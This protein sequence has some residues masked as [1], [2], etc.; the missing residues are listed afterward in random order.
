MRAKTL[1]IIVFGVAVGL[2][3]GRFLWSGGTAVETG[4]PSAAT[5]RTAATIWT[6]SMHPQ[7][8]LPSPGQCPI[9]GMDLIPAVA[10]SG[11]S[12]E[13]VLGEAAQKIAS[14]ETARVERRVLERE[15]RTVGRIELAEP[16]VSYLTARA[17]GRVERVFADF[18][19]T[20]VA[21]GDHLVDIYAPAL[22]IAQEELLIAARNAETGPGAQ[23]ETWGLRLKLARQKVLLLGLTEGQI[24]ALIKAKEP[25]FVLTVFAPVGGTVMSKNVQRQMYVKAGDPLYTIADLS[26]VWLFADIYEFELPWVALGQ[27]A[28]VEVEGVPGKAFAGTLDFIEPRVNEATRTIRVRLT[29]ENAERLLKPGMFAR[30]MILARIGPD[31]LRAAAPVRGRYYCRMH[32]EYTSDAP[33]RCAF[34][35]MELIGRPESQPASAPADRVVWTC[36]MHPEIR[37]DGPGECPICGM[38]LVEKKE[39]GVQDAERILAIPVDAVLDSGLRR[40]VYVERAPGKYEAVEVRLGPRAGEFYPVLEG[41]E[42]GLH[43]VARGGFL[44]DSQAQIEGRPSL[45]FPKGLAGAS[46]TSGHGGH[47]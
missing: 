19:G 26:K 8:R 11:V 6:C 22:V 37:R 16:L 45:L 27:A 39:A 30:A 10:D 13:V 40:I 7:I 31:G 44:L 9:C 42:E 20:E 18:T 12:R 29:L 23:A 17:D 2:V 28:R 46:E 35:G 43:V 24:D 47:R 32:P 41:L 33:G 36:P 38:D 1:L 21:K 14:I 4:P 5:S 25:D 3:A 15:I 34:C